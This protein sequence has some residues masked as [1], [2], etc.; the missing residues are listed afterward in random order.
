[1]YLPIDETYIDSLFAQAES[2]L[3]NNPYTNIG[4][5]PSFFT[6]VKGIAMEGRQEIVKNLT[7][8]TP[9]YLER[10]PLNPY[11]PNAIKVMTGDGDCIGFLSRQLALVI[12]PLMDEGEE[13]STSISCITGGNGKNYGVNLLILKESA[14]QI[15]IDPGIRK[16]LSQLP[17]KALRDKIRKEVLGSWDYHGKQKEAINTL[18]NGENVLAIFGTG[19]G[20]SAIFQ[21]VAAY[22]ALKEDKITVIVYPLRALSND[23]YLSMQ[24]MFASLGLRI[25]RANGGLGID[26]RRAVFNAI[27]SGDID[28]LLT[29]PEFLLYHAEKLGPILDR[30]DLFVVDESHHVEDRHR[31]AYRRLD[32]VVSLLGNPQVLAVTATANTDTAKKIVDMLDIQKVII[33]NHVRENLDI[34]DARNCRD[35]ERYMVNVVKNAE[36]AIVYVGTRKESVNLATKLRETIP[37]FHHKVGF[38]HGG[39]TSK[40]RAFIEQMFRDDYI[41]VVVATSAFG[42]GINIPNVSDVLLYG[43]MYNFTE[44]NQQAGRAGRNGEP[45][46]IH[47]LFGR[48]DTGL[49]WAIMRSQAPTREQVY[50]VYKALQGAPSNVSNSELAQMV[51]KMGGKGCNETLVSTSLGILEELKLIQRETLGNKRTIELLAQSGEIRIIDSLR[52]MEGQEELEE[53][54]KFQKDIL[55]LPKDN[56]IKLVQKPI[57]PNLNELFKEDQKGYEWFWL[58]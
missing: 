55:S 44:F 49:N 23:Q 39:M 33:D 37:G 7:E 27:N 34:Y 21:T 56:L 42:E 54:T 29:T 11:D 2:F 14:Y 18:L 41:K 47:L 24:R 17:E 36:K 12:A 9:V 25:Y 53:F 38:Y 26:D 31:S 40:D 30:I 57:Y 45:A 6:K 4:D 22:R 16:L 46:R 15:T 19:R 58:C 13:Y 48:A 28:I 8:D 35:K 5:A 3:S 1:M 51:K 50:L 10:D 20:K 52:Y 32:R 43:M